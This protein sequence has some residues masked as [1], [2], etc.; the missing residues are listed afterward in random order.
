MSTI[1]A[2]GTP[3]GKGGVAMIRISGEDAFSVAEKIFIP[4]NPDN[5][6]KKR[7]FK[8]IYR[9]IVWVKFNIFRNIR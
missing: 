2:V 7:T 1:A 6:A 9:F 8:G 4:Q 3:H 5:F